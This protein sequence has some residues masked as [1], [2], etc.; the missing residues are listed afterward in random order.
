MHCP[1]VS[2]I[3]PTYNGRLHLEECFHSL[4]ALDY[5]REQREIIVV[6]NGSSDDS[7]AY[8]TAQYP[9]AIIVQNEQNLGFAAACNMGAERARST[10]L[11]FLN[12]DTRV[13]PEWLQELTRSI[14]TPT[15]GSEN[16]VCVAGRIVG[17]DGQLLDYD[18]GIVNFHGHGH[19]LRAGQPVS[20]GA[21][22][23]QPT[24]FACAASMLIQRNVFLD[25]GG[26]D[27]DYFAYFEDVDL[28]WRLWL[29]GYQVLYCPN[30]I[31]FHRG[32]G[33]VA[34]AKAERKKLL[35]R[36]GLFTIFKNY[37]SDVLERTL[38]PAMS[39]VAKKAAV[40]QDDSAAYLDAITE[41]VASLEELKGK[42]QA[43]QGRRKVGD[44]EILP[45]FRQPFRP[46]M[47]D[48]SYWKLQCRLVTAYG[49]DTLFE[50]EWEVMHQH[51]TIIEDLYKLQRDTAEAHNIQLAK[52]RQETETLRDRVRELEALVQAK[53]SQIQLYEQLTQ[54]TLRRLD[55]Y[56]NLEN[57]RL[58]TRIGRRLF[59]RSD[60]RT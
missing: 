33:T 48:E 42:R 49:L 47:H 40:D 23:L 53:D 18:G 39:L 25:V 2:I 16:V 46:S 14:E 52:A 55:E 11:A 44:S 27:T 41:F 34:L 5:P 56:L 59:G 26:F 57:N 6:D 24:I 4:S 30:A 32:Q 12:N 58:F 7:V 15:S 31:V 10:Y 22:D 43:I 1:T 50:K 36:N 35:E 60:Q 13:D 8:L 3:I 9:E 20:A 51:E 45:L 54:E 38:L 37:S 29:F 17:W 21:T 28:G 19:H